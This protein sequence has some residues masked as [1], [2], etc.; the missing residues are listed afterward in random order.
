MLP[1]FFQF[2]TLNANAFFHLVLHVLFVLHSRLQQLLSILLRHLI[3]I[4]L[5]LLILILLIFFLLV[6]L[7]FNFSAVYRRPSYPAFALAA[8]FGPDSAAGL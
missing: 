3:L 4:L 5:L 6:L 1:V 2:T 7:F 8:Y